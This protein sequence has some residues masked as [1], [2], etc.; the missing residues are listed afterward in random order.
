MAKTREQKKEIVASVEASI[1][2]AVS[3]VFVHFTGVSVA[4][5]SKLRRAFRADGLGYTVAK[6]TLIR[7]ALDNLGYDHVSVP[8]DGEIAVAYNTASSDPT[9]PANRI[10]SFG[11]EWGP[12]KLVILGGIFDGKFID[13]SAMQEIATIPSLNVLRGKL[14]NLISSPLTRLAMVMDQ[15]AQK[16]Q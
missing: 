8:M 4:Q 15:R 14:V 12:E 1:K 2:G 9:L 16:M 5:E 3:S 10:H 13:A 7:R 11:K 6:K